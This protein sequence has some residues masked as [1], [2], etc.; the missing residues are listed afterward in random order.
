MLYN[1][2]ESFDQE[3]L[4]D[5]TTTC[6]EALVASYEAHFEG[7]VPAAYQDKPLPYFGVDFTKRHFYD[8]DS[9]SSLAREYLDVSVLSLDHVVH[10]NSFQ[11]S[12]DVSPDTYN[13]YR[14]LAENMG[15]IALHNDL[16]LRRFVP[17]NG[18]VGRYTASFSNENTRAVDSLHGPTDKK[19]LRG[20]TKLA[21]R[22]IKYMQTD[23]SRLT[24]ENKLLRAITGETD[25]ILQHSFTIKMTPDLPLNGHEGEQFLKQY[26]N[27]M[28]TQLQRNHLDLEYL[29]ALG[30]SEATIERTSQQVELYQRALQRAQDFLGES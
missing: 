27:K 14:T 25:D 15:N 5:F 21:K 26:R 16:K 3:K 11:T 22:A 20:A 9:P 24:I 28:L 17:S 30:S 23:E 6:R 8:D 19:S 29:I 12:Q 7:H 10:M 18:V 4:V 13:Y 1:N 2:N